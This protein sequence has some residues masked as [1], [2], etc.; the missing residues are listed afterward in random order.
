MEFSEI[1]DAFESAGLNVRSYSGRGMYG[2]S[3]LGVVTDKSG[4][5]L[6]CEVIQEL[7][8]GASDDSETVDKISD[9]CSELSDP[10]EDSMGLSTIVYWPDIEWQSDSD[11]CDDDE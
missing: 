11:G 5:A 6:V 2:R 8:S 3:C 9:L 4:A 10:S 1:K 7:I